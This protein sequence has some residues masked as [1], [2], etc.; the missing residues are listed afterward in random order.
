V[1]FIVVHADIYSY[2]PLF[3]EHN[4]E[5]NIN[6][7]TINTIKKYQYKWILKLFE[8]H[9]RLSKF[10]YKTR[11]RSKRKYSLRQKYK[12]IKYS[13]YSKFLNIKCMLNHKL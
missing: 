4:L 13:K 6:K 2:M 7:Y 8:S 12:N 10:R 1:T 11:L 5:N 9:A 3:V